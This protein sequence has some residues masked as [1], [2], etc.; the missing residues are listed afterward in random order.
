MASVACWIS[1]LL[2]NAMLRHESKVT[3]WADATTEIAQSAISTK[4]RMVSLRK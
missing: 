3:T 4:F 2:R 1:L